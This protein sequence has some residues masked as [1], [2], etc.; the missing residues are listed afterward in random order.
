LVAGD[1]QHVLWFDS[2]TDLLQYTDLETVFRFLHLT[3]KRIA[4]VEAT[5]YY[6]LTADVHDDQTIATLAPLF[7]T[8]L[9]PG[10][11]PGEWTEAA[12]SP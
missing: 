4:D 8:V 10:P 2:V 5:G 11:A 12:S 9:K 3:T 6:H 1:G 7:E